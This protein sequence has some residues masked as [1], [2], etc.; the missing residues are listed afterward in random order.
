MRAGD[1]RSAPL[2]FV[3][4]G[5]TGAYLVQMIYDAERMRHAWSYTDGVP[6]FGILSD[7]WPAH[8]HTSFW[9]AVTG[10]IVAAA[11]T[12]P[13]LVIRLAAGPERARLPLFVIGVLASVALLSPYLVLAAATYAG[14]AFWLLLCVPTTAAGLW[15]TGR[16]QPVRRMPWWLL[17]AAFA[18]GAT[19]AY[20][21]GHA[22]NI[23]FA[24]WLPGTL[25]PDADDARDILE[26][27]WQADTL[28]QILG[29]AAV[30]LGKGA[31][32]GVL[33]LLARQRITGVPSGLALGAAAGLGVNLALTV[34]T[35]G[36]FPYWTHQVVG[37]LAGD[38]AFTA[39]TG[40]AFGATRQ[41]GVP[42]LRRIIV[43]CG[44]LAAIGTHAFSNI[45]IRGYVTGAADET[46][47]RTLV[48]SPLVMLA[49]QLPALALCGWLLWSGT[50]TERGG[51]SAALA[52]E[53]ATGR[54]A[55]LAEEAAVLLSPVRRWSVSADVARRSGWAGLRALGRLFAAQDD[56]AAAG[57]AV[58]RGDA[59]A[60]ETAA[61]T[62]PGGPGAVAPGIASA[63]PGVAPGQPGA[64]S[65]QPDELD[66]LRR[67]VMARKAEFAAVTG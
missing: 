2:V 47:V 49:T 24:D 4:L 67:Q 13:A 21:F 66:V 18:W 6:V 38:T 15:L 12:L 23:W 61:A 40:A 8:V 48:V 22:M 26:A 11:L 16:A 57:W 19:V 14:H 55:V 36:V 41:I 59:G 39:L 53:T 27:R 3:S 37:L 56:L 44:F 28:L 65:A 63:A 54:G 52:A 35:G 34:A 31:G 62:A 32:V 51:L 10:G 42:K 17:T 1:L 30:E 25:A 29:A 58:L 50:R 9:A 33:L 43:T 45:M 60:A 7:V 46:L 5:M 20:G 64:S